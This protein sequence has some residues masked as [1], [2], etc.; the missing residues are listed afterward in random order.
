[1]RDL[2]DVESYVLDPVNI[3]VEDS[4]ITPPPLLVTNV[5]DSATVRIYPNPSLYATTIE[6]ELPAGVYT[7]RVTGINGQIYEEQQLSL[8]SAGTLWRSIDVSKLANGYYVIQLVRN[9]G[10]VGVY[11]FIIRR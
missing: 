6:A 11:P 8:E 5:Q 2:S 1:M 7:A 10:V 9:T 4:N 3:A